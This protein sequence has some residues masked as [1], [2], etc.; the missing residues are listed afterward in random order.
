MF[1]IVSMEGIWIVNTKPRPCSSYSKQCRRHIRA[2]F[3]AIS[4]EM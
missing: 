2:T 1:Q 4:E 3:K